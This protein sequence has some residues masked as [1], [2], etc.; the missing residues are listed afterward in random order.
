MQYN[1]DVSF[2]VWNEFHAIIWPLCVSDSQQGGGFQFQL[3]EAGFSSHLMQDVSRI[4][5]FW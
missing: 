3:A 4:F 2:I 5:G 1:I